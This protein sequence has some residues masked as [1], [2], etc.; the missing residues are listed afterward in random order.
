[1]STRLPGGADS[2]EELWKLVMEQRDAVSGFPLDR[3]WDLE[4]LY[5]PDPAHPGTSYTRS[6]GFLHEAAQF[7]A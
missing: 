3:G 5:H 4:G 7:D 2:P 1:M 6:G